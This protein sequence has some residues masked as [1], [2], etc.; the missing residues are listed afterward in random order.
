ME[1]IPWKQGNTIEKPCMSATSNHE[2]SAR[3]LHYIPIIHSQADMGALSES[4][5]RAGQQKLGREQW[6]Q[7][8]RT[9]DQLWEEIELAIDAAALPPA[10][11]R[12]YQDGLPV[13]SH[14]HEIVRD[15]VTKGSKN[16][17]ILQRLMEKGATVMGTE[18]PELLIKEYNLARQE[19]SAPGERAGDRTDN[20]GNAEKDTL[21]KQRDTYIAQRINSTLGAGETGVLFI[22]LLH[23]VEH[24]LDRDILV[25]YPI[26]RPL[27][28]R[29]A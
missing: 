8:E 29:V 3:T 16:Y 25:L 23:N 4:I 13:C 27:I 22:G 15:L 2:A 10:K 19:F 24:L 26:S 28:K 18:S 7:K 14:V 17:Q 12:L 9:V 20:A 6:Q 1:S 5:S 21:L 11:T